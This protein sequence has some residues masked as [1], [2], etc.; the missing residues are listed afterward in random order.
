MMEGVNFLRKLSKSRLDVEKGKFG[1]AWMY[2]TKPLKEEVGFEP[3]Y[4]MEDGIKKTYE[5]FLSRST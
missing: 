2:D 5:A 4:S 3:K 1:I